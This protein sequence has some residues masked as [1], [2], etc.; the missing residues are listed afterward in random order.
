MKRTLEKIQEDID[1]RKREVLTIN[2]NGRQ[3][4]LKLFG[5][6]KE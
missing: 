1:N 3:K 5:L 2:S 6:Y 4:L